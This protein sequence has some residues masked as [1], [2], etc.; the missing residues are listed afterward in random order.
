MTDVLP[1]VVIA[2]FLFMCK[3]LGP[4]DFEAFCDGYTAYAV[5]SEARTRIREGV[6]CRRLGETSD[7][8]AHAA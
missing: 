2:E 7:R 4:L 5:W 3:T 6:D 1:Q 8:D